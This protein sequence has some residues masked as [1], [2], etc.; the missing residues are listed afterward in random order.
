LVNTWEI[1]IITN[2]C[3]GKIQTTYDELI[4]NCD[5]LSTCMELNKQSF[6]NHTRLL[7]RHWGQPQTHT[8][9][10]FSISVFTLIQ[11]ILTLKAPERLNLCTCYRTMF[12]M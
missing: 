6:Q 8:F 3:Q 12:K 7:A 2:A 9:P 1:S 11:N 10:L 4:N 5:I